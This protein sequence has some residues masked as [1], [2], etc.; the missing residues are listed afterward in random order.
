MFA[1]IEEHSEAPIRSGPKILAELLEAVTELRMS[2]CNEGS[3]IAEGWGQPIERA[4]FA[5]SAAN[6]ANF[7]PFGAVT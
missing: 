3:Q 7:W 2:V 6:L 5:P 4:S 1:I